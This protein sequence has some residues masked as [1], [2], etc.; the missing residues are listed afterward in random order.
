MFLSSK[1]VEA[2]E[3]AKMAIAIHAIANTVRT[4]RSMTNGD[5]QAVLRLH[6]QS[7]RGRTLFVLAWF[8]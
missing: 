2:G 7:R 6:L 4:L 1:G 3:K 5:G 8:V